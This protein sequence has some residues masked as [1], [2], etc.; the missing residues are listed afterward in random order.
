MQ[1]GILKAYREGH[2]DYIKACEKIGISYKVIDILAPDWLTQVQD[3][4]CDGFLCHPPCDITEQK[5]IYDEK[6]YFINKILNFPVYPSF[7]EIFVYENKRNMAYWLQSHNLPHP[8]TFIFGRKSEAKEFVKSSQFPLVFKTSTGASSSGVSIIRSK[9]QAF[10]HINQVFGR[11][12]P[13]L[14]IGKVRFIKNEKNIPIPVLGDPQKHYLI[15][16]NFHKIK[17]EW[18]IVKI[19]DSYFGHQKLLKG[20]FASGSLQKGW[21]VPPEELLRLVKDLCKQGSFYSMAVDIFETLDN[22]F[23]INE[24]QCIF[25]QSTQDLMIK[26]GAPGRC[27]FEESSNTFLFEEGNFNEF[28]SKL[29]RVEHFIKILKEKKDIQ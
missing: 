17:H 3:A 15:V 9:S 13:L 25:G 27:Y 5:H 22:Q 21:V 29:L 1:L 16:Q 28:N 18:R 14:A 10:R 11:F 2:E 19:G 4:K 23:L 20:D 26:E 8:T 6:V 12:H 7:N 24:L